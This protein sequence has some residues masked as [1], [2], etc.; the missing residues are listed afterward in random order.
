MKFCHLLL[1]KVTS[2]ETSD[3]PYSSLSWNLETFTVLLLK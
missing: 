2:D 1:I 3:L